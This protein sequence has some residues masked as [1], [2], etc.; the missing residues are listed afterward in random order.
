MLAGV[1]ALRVG[2]GR[3]TMAVAQSVAAQV[4]TAVPEAAVVGLPETDGSFADDALRTIESSVDSA[5]VVVLGPGLDEPRSARAMLSQLAPMT[6]GTV[7]VDAFAL[8]V[9][10]DEGEARSRLADRMILTPNAQEAKFLLDD[11]S[12]DGPDLARRIAAEYDAVVTCSG[13]VA[14][15]HGSRW[16]LSTGRPGLATSGSGDV[17]AGAIAGLVARRADGRQAAAWA[18]YLHAAAG[19]RLAARVGPIGYLARELVDELPKV[20][21][22]I[23]P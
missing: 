12:V 21:V 23:G 3:L 10:R 6:D 16:Q 18:T 13:T 15:S 19:D 9:L 8:G 7:I 1:A 11:D 20:M 2:A 5:D 14:D 17:L 22:E 4:A